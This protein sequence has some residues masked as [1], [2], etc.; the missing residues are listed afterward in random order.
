MEHVEPTPPEVREGLRAIARHVKP[1]KK[2]LWILIA[3][4]VVSAIANGFVPYI[5]GKFFDALIQ[6][7]RGESS[8]VA[9]NI[10]LWVFLLSVWAFVQ[11][12]ANNIDWVMDRMRRHV[13]TKVHLNIQTQG[14]IHLLRLP[15]SYHKNVHING[16]LQKLSQ[17]GWRVSAIL[18]TIINFAPQFLSIL[19]GI[20][21]A[22]SINTMLASI[23]V[24][25]VVLYVL[26][27]VRILRPIAQIDSDAHHAWNEGWDDAAASIHQIESVKQ[28]AAEE[29][30][31]Q[32]IREA[33]SGKARLL[34]E[35]M[36]NLWSN[37]GFFQRII[38]FFAQLAIFI[39]S[40]RLVSEG[41]ITVGEL[42]ALNG[43]AAM[44]FGPF[45][46]L[47]Y[48]W[49]VIQN[50][51]TSAA[52]A[53]EI[54]N[55]PEERYVPE[56]AVAP[57][58]ISG[59]VTFKNVS[60]SYG[61]DQPPVLST[62]DLD[63]HPGEV[64]ALVGESGVG[65]STTISLLSGYYFPTDG[66]V[67]IDDVDTRTYDLTALRQ[68]I[69][70][71]PQEVALF[72]DTIRNN[73]RYGT[74]DASD[75][76]IARAAHEAHIDDMIE[77]LPAGYDTVVGERGIKLSV[78]QKQRVSIARAILRDPAILILDEPTSALDAKTEQIVTKALEKL[79]KG[80][81]TFIIAHRLSTVREA[82]TI[83]VFEKGTIAERGT[84]QELIAKEDG[85]YRN[86]YE[87]QIGLH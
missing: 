36:E 52:H 35:K 53:E 6:L 12:V 47:G 37:V 74:P 26:L 14:F 45:V 63:I 86:L 60:F 10:P 13:D 58:T 8:F 20:T 82:D 22:A 66:A 25:G 54:F 77:K 51:I 38:V 80:R 68:R 83:L 3:L 16:T 73:I 62:I 32:T 23:L 78:G 61:S 70:V 1:F 2:E 41:T 21:L 57:K 43:Y 4:G 5:T 84:H 69:A 72:N 11:L 44:F 59:K 7:S 9:S 81:T 48:S 33:L 49:Q 71:V 29:Y 85:V 55:V 15:L 19:I 56:N 17:A 76:D 18:R 34:W 79:M 40:V 27:L 50:G 46:S 75:D 39:L 24:L 30:E 42:V 31:I 87:Y 65:K 67:L 28:A 64:I